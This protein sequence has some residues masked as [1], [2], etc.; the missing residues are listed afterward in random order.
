MSK[1]MGVIVWLG[2]SILA[3]L[4]AATILTQTAHWGFES[5]LLALLGIAIILALG[6]LAYAGLGEE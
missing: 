5:V 4:T 6:G 2:T 1:L 3:S